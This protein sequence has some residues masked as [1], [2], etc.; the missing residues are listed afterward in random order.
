MPRRFR[1]RHPLVRRAVYDSAPAGWL[2]GAHERSAAALAGRGATATER[3]HHVERSG[4]QGDARCRRRPPR[5]RRGSRPPCPG[6]RRPVVR[7]CTAAAPRRCPRGGSGRAS[8]RA[9]AGALATCGHFAE[10]HAALLESYRL[11]PA[12]AVALR[13]RL[14]TACA[15]I[16]HLLGLHEAAHQRLTDALA[17]L[18]DPASPEAVALMLEL[19]IGRRLHDAVPPDRST[20][21]SGPSTPPDRSGDRTADRHRRRRAGLGHGTV[22]PRPRGGEVPRR[23]GRAGRRISRTATWPRR[24]DSAVHLAGAELYLDRF[25]AAGDHAERV[26]AVA[27]ATGQPAFIP[28]AFMILAWVQMLRGELAD[29]AAT[30][31]AAIEESRLLRNDQSL[32]GILLNRSLTALA[33]GDLELAVSTAREA[34]DLTRDMDAGLVPRRRPRGPVRGA[35]RVRRPRPRRRRR[36]HGPTVRRARAAVRCR[37]A[38]SAPSGSSCS[39]DARSRSDVQADAERAAAAAQ[40]TVA[41]MGGLRM[42]TAMAERAAA[43]VALEAGISSSP[44]EERS[45][46]QPPRTKSASPS[47]PPSHAPSPGVRS[48]EPVNPNAPS[49][50]S[51]TAAADAARLRCREVPG[52]SGAGAE[53]A[54]TS[55]PPIERGPGEAGG[56]GL[57]S[58]T[59]RERQVADLV[60][61]ATPTPRSPRLSSSAR[62]PWR[63]TFATSS[64]S[65]TSPHASVSHGLSNEPTAKYTHLISRRLC[66]GSHDRPTTRHPFG[67]S[68]Y[69]PVPRLA[70]FS[71]TFGSALV[72]L[73]TS[74]R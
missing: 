47:R 23:G 54:G 67:T 33:A 13:I 27:R 16:E 3:A 50:S 15:G 6:E 34:V 71:S 74:S 37:A 73:V 19:A 12:D 64:T 17:D 2:L 29:G 26:I 5:G 31:D 70:P 10:S 48:R 20:S 65:S 60:V 51:S 46:R 59:E 42:A 49:P 4:R 38:A 69:R 35:P 72:S 52:R 63:P 28:L 45:P 43:A 22:R 66:D 7:R 53:A 9:R 21:P 1:F 11:A 58:L 62:R 61:A 39:P 40:D 18:D 41:S 25:A 55:R 32:A 68:R 30:L 36:P 24:L 56:H 14:T 8:P 57:E 44:R